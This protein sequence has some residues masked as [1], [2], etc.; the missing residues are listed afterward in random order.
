[1]RKDVLAPLEKVYKGSPSLKIKIETLHRKAFKLVANKIM[2]CLKFPDSK[3]MVLAVLFTFH[4][5]H[6]AETNNCIFPHL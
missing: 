4:L 1:M 2:L 3:G 5:K 6:N